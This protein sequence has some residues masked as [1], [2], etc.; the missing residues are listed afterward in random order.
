MASDD[1]SLAGWRQFLGGGLQD[2]VFYSPGT[3]FGMT[4]AV[5]N[6]VLVNPAFCE[7]VGYSEAELL[8]RHIHEITHP[9]DRERE[10]DMVHGL[11][12]DGPGWY[13]LEKR[14]LHRDGRAIWVTL[15]VV[16]IRD[17]E[18]NPAYFLGQATDIHQQKLTEGILQE[19]AERLEESNQILSVILGH[20]DMM[21]VYLDARFNFIW[22]NRAYAATCGHE[23]DFFP[24]RNHFELYPNPNN[25]AIF[26]RVVDT[27]EPYFVAAKPFVFP[28]QPERGVTYWDWSLVPVRNSAGGVSR[29]VFTLVDVTER[30]RTEEEQRVAAQAVESRERL[31]TFA[32]EADARVEQERKR[33]AAE[34]H[35]EL[36]QL[37]T[38]LKMD[39]GLAATCPGAVGELGELLEDM[40]RRIDRT[41]GVVKHVVNHLR[42]AVL[43]VGLVPALEWLAD[44]MLRH[45][46]QRCRLVLPQEDIDTAD[47]HAT[48][49]FRVAQES[50]TNVVRHAN[51]Q[52]V[53]L[54]LRPQ[55]RYLE[56]VVEDDGRGF[57]TEA[58]RRGGSHGLTG[59]HERVLA[60]DGSLVI[61]SVPGGGTRIRVRLPLTA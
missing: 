15:H 54:V 6:L 44:D 3:G 5:G 14:Y 12:K 55:P 41:L 30:K 1:Y 36:G 48:A 10:Y 17:G 22:V 28:D 2:L 4:D 21:A 33:I 52:E 49:L 51:A 57:D 31:R 23:A 61:D 16:L 26:Q 45:T 56:M 8:G 29:L 20:T 59:M 34:V 37:L 43:N 42:P 11:S 13:R 35:D 53:R 58:A 40:R 47:R 60:L 27:G 46:G 32:A 9:D 19:R 25:Q 24:G 18:G 39:A 50:L 38:S 7:L